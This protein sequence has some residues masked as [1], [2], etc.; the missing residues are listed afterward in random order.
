[1]PLAVFT[2]IAKEVLQEMRRV[3]RENEAKPFPDL[4]RRVNRRADAA[5]CTVRHAPR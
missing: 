4:V 3:V 5:V 1:M 2:R